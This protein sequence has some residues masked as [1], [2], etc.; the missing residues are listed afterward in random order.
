MA[1]GVGFDDPTAPWGTR[2]AGL[3][4]G[5]GMGQAWYNNFKVP[6]QSSIR[7]SIQ[8]TDGATHGGFYMI[9]RGGLGLPLKIGNNELPPTARLQLQK[10]EGPMEPLE[11]LNVVSVP[12]G[13]SGQIF[14]TALAVN[15]SG[16]GGYNFLEGETMDVF[17]LQEKPSW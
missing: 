1:S 10:F 3:G 2:W 9:V 5:N 13:S 7:V 16:I 17:F 14:M 6:F 8:S 4:A 15:N 12:K 11:W